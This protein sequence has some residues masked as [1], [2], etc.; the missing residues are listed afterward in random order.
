M[1][2]PLKM[3]ADASQTS[4]PT[5][6]KVLMER[7]ILAAQR[8]DWNAKNNLARTFTPLLTS[9]ASKRSSD[10]SKMNDY[11]EAGK[12]GLFNA[13]KRYKAGTA[14]RFNIFVLDFVE[15]EMNG[16]DKGGGFFARLFGG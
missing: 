7:E 9:L 11:I 3:G 4:G 16:V 8:G 6:A 14:D 15:K 12:K 5:Q 10:V 1:R 13:V 2:I